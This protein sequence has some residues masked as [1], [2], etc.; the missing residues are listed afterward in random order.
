MKKK[1]VLKYF[2][3][4]LTLAMLCG[5]EPETSLPEP[6]DNTVSDDE[7][8]EETIETQEADQPEEPE[9][10][11]TLETTATGEIDAA[12]WDKLIA[13]TGAS[14]D[15]VAAYV[16]DDFDGDGVNEAFVLVGIETDDL[17]D[18]KQIYGSIWFVSHERCDNL[19]SSVGMGINNTP[20]TM[21]LGDTKYVY[22][23]DEFVSESYSVVF[24]VSDGFVCD[25]D[26]SCVGAVGSSSSDPDTFTIT[27]S[28]YDM[29]LDVEAG[30]TIGHTY[31]KYYFFYDSEEDRIY[32]YAGTSIDAATAEFWSGRDLVAELVPEGDTVTDIFM[33][34]NGL[35]A[36][37]YEHTDS[38]GNIEYY[39]YIYS[40][41]SESLVDDL[42]QETG[43]AAL[44]G[45]YLHA[46]CPLM[47]SYPEVPGPDGN[48]WYGE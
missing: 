42:G 26:F 3:L 48:V 29:Y 39:H 33:R 7:E 1:N 30:F 20:H 45:I 36:I 32:E 5:C 19:Y 10:S 24:Y 16:C 17:G 12:L 8:E 41:V 15:E 9:E 31:K 6:S 37:N 34:G 27:D 11:E 13:E 28:S 43:E 21:T 22:F 4:S 23:N 35:I 18:H 14:E 44:S 40:T 2:C 38:D 46:R 47:A 25:A